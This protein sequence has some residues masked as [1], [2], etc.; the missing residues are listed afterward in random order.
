VDSA[1]GRAEA[2]RNINEAPATNRQIYTSQHIKTLAFGVFEELRRQKQLCD[3]VIHIGTA[4]FSAHRVILAAASPYFRSMFT[5]ELSESRQQDVTLREVDETAMEL[6][7]RFVYIG[8]IEVSEENVQTLL[9][10]ANLLQLTEV[11]DCCCDFLRKQLDPTNVLG[12]ISFADLHSC[13]E[14]L[15]EAQRYAR[16]HFPEVRSSEEF[17]T[18]PLNSIIELISSD[19]LGVLAEEDVFEAVI[20]W[21]KH[22]RP[23]REIHLSELIRHVRYEL[24]SSNYVLKHVAEE[25]IININPDCKDF[26]IQALKYHLMS[27]SERAMHSRQVN[28]RVRVGGPQSIVIVGGQAPKAIRNIEIYDVKNHVCKL[29]PVLVSRRCRCGVTVLNG[30]VYAVGGFDGSSRVRSVEQLDL[31]RVCWVPVEAMLSRRSTLGVGVL[32]GEL[33]AVGGFDGN[34]GLDSVEKY[35]PDTKQWVDVAP[36][37]TPRSRVRSVEQLDLNRV[38]WVPVEAMLSRRSTLGVGVLNGELYAVGGFDGNNGLDSVEKYNPDTKQWVDV[39]PMGTPRSSVGV[40][41]MSGY[42]YAVGGY[43]GVARLC[44]NS[45]ERYNPRTDK[46]GYI[47]A[48]LQRR[49]GAAVAVM[50]NLLYAIGGH[51]GPDIRRSVE[52]FDPNTGKWG[53][54]ADMNT[55]RRN[56]AAVVVHNMLYVVGGD[57]GITN[58]SSIEIFDPVSEVWKFAEGGLT[59]GRSYAGVTVIEKACDQ[60]FQE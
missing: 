23:E 41:V 58:L 46:W 8:S 15:N 14:L 50:D 39:A 4:E 43:D 45:V 59:Q 20:Q 53:R 3:V 38:C 22:N 27:P 5:G 37:G 29:G 19:E 60:L 7:I 40:A 33:Y 48:M 52:R 9:P 47:D 18:L 44:L 13:R 16:K 49:S 51:N 31:N 21:V 6:L 2:D 36:M 17:I 25:E 35:N 30:S 24:L 55:P 34:N 28:S 56:A 54:V 42:L 12:I 11:R 26:I 32:N 10:A 1:E 57:N